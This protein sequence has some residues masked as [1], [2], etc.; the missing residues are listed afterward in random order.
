MMVTDQNHQMLPYLDLQF[1]N[2]NIP[3]GDPILIFGK[4]LMRY[5]ERSN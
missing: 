4:S 5:G 1:H 2:L 3:V